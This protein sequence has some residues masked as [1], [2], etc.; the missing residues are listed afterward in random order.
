MKYYKRI[1]NKNLTTTVE[2]YSFDAPIQGAVEIDKAEFDDFIT[3]LP[4]PPPKEK[5][6]L[7]LR[8]EVLESELTILKGAVK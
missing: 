7:E 3:K 5:S 2:S 8:V 4:P 6:A 1:D